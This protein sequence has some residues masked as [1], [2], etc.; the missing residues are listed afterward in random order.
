MGDTAVFQAQNMAG[1]YGS[2]VLNSNGA[3][4]YTLNNSLPAV[5]GLGH[6]EQLVE[7]F[8][9][10]ANDGHGGITARTISFTINGTNDAPSVGSATVSMN[11]AT[12]KL[13]GKLPTPTDPDN[14]L[15]NIISDNVTFIPRPHVHGEYG[16]FS[17]NADG[18]YVYDLNTGLLS[19]VLLTLGAKLTDRFSYTVVDEHGASA[20]NTIDIVITGGLLGS[21]SLTTILDGATS[22]LGNLLVPEFSNATFS[23]QSSPNG[24]YGTLTLNSNGTYTYNLSAQ[25]ISESQKLGEGETSTDVF[26]VKVTSG[27]KSVVTPLT[28][29]I[30]GS[31][32]APTVQPSQLS[33]SEDDVAAMYGQLVMADP[34]RSDTPRAVPQ[35]TEG[36]Y[37]TFFLN[38]N[39]SYTYVLNKDSAIVKALNNG[40]TLDETFTVTVVDG[41]GGSAQST[42]TVTIHG[43]GE[44][45]LMQ[46][47]SAMRLF[48]VPDEVNA[49]A[50]HEQLQATTE[51]HNAATQ[52]SQEAAPH[53]DP[54]AD[55]DTSV[56]VADSSTQTGHENTQSDAPAA[57]AT[58]ETTEHAPAENHTASTAEDSAQEQ[59]HAGATHKDMADA[60]ATHAEAASADAANTSQTDVSHPD[61]S[62][63]DTN[64]AETEHAA[65]SAPDVHADTLDEELADSFMNDQTGPLIIDLE[66]AL[67]PA[68]QGTDSANSAQP[69]AALD[70]S[71]FPVETQSPETLAHAAEAAAHDALAASPDQPTQ[72]QAESTSPQP[73]SAEAQAAP[74]AASPSPDIME[75]ET[76]QMAVLQHLTQNGH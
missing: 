6:G 38:P 15:D 72:A 53:A 30:V 25:G 24:Q 32:D 70:D 1:L 54:Y 39:G 22:L 68:A 69:P 19:V 3:Y 73:Q 13:Y 66:D 17:L 31:N 65:P 42:V 64:N 40:D 48:F 14:T 2:F 51:D 44:A 55:T 35:T 61:A 21:I 46:G 20:T 75:S 56:P 67:H 4:V 18:S 36:Q 60:D 45:P 71:L 63:A 58:P 28:I 57:A 34:D 74:A 11:N 76:D 9:V 26:M 23:L 8:T 10:A 47:A 29:T 7:T 16:T 59:T 52:N 37:G 43:S 50:S 41:H 27:L 62:H 12:D 33:V 5:Q 49:S